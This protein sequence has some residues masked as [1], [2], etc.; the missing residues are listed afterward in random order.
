M[1][2]VSPRRGSSFATIGITRVVTK[3][4][5]RSGRPN[6]TAAP[7]KPTSSATNR[8]GEPTPLAAHSPNASAPDTKKAR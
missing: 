7:A 5:R 6:T 1:R 4:R 3:R 2:S 8:V